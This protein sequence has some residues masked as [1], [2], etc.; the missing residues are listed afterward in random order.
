M[1][2]TG[3][4][5]IPSNHASSISGTA[6]QAPS[7]EAVLDALKM[8]LLDAPLA[9]VLTSVV[10]LIEAQSPRMLCSI[11]LLDADGVHLRYG[12]APSLPESYRS[13]TE[14]MAS[15]PNAGSC[16]TAVHRREAVFVPDIRTDPRWASFREFA[17]AA[18]L[19]AAWSSPIIASDGRVLGTF[20][21]YYCEVPY[22]TASDIHLIDHASRIA[23]IAIEREQSQVALK[24]A[25]D[26]IAKSEAQLRQMVDAIRHDVWCWGLMGAWRT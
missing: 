13:A 20:G 11:F 1:A 7:G 8:I 17:A 19:R 14:G 5:K 6:A 10:L 21:I 4:Q 25:F 2:D 24:G 18:G 16:G 23:A 26:K 3:T 15:G 22:P 12:A 9:E